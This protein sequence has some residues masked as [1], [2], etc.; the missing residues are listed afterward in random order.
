MKRM[1]R[2]VGSILLTAAMFLSLFPAGALDAEPQEAPPQTCTCT[3]LCT[4]EAADTLC[5]VCAEDITHCTGK[6]TEPQEPEQPQ[7]PEVPECTCTVLCTEETMD[8]QC[9]ACAAGVANCTGKAAEPQE[10]EQPQEPEVPECTCTVLCTEDAVDT[11]CP[12][13]A[14]DIT[15][16]AG[17]PVSHPPITLAPNAADVIYVSDGGTGDGS[18]E[19]SC[20]DFETAMQNAQ[21]GDTFI[22]VGSVDLTSGTWKP[23]HAV[24]QWQ[25]QM[26]APH[27][28]F[29]ANRSGVPLLPSQVLSLRFLFRGTSFLMT[30][31]LSAP[32][33]I[34][35]T[36]LFTQSLRMVII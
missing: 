32:C 12:A 10:P 4:E 22:V 23:P 30:L 6:A 18:S 14:E 27:L 34:V 19:A 24:L 1:R 9:P 5:P 29:S 20:A 25:A 2:K 13:C 8:A 36:R 26:P 35:T 7:Q 16:C 11:L 3:V 17:E 21:E 31:S 33:Q 28:S 15:G